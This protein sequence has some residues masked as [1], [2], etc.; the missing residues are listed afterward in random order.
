M[1]K[2]IPQTI[3]WTIIILS[4]LLTYIPIYIEIY[5]LPLR[6]FIWIFSPFTL[7]IGIGLAISPK[8]TIK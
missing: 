6:I 7:I 1:F 8:K 5:G 3:G 4:I 2:Q